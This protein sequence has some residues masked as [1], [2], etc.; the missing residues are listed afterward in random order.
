M[1]RV[2]LKKDG[3]D[4]DLIAFF[5]PNSSGGRVYLSLLLSEDEGN[6]WSHK[7]LCYAPANTPLHLAVR[8]AGT[9]Q[10]LISAGANIHAKSNWGNT[11]LHEATL[12]GAIETV[13]ILMRAG[14]DTEAKDEF[15]ETPLDLAEHNEQTEIAEYLLELG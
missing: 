15:G 12:A 10:F 8:D 13:K 2:A 9:A 14:A 11:P 3:D 5:N 7:E 1:L 4:R 6:T